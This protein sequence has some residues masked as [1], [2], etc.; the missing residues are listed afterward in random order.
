MVFLV[1]ILK[2]L[3]IPTPDNSRYTEKYGLY[4]VKKIRE[5]ELEEKQSPGSWE[6]EGLTK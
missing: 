6:K 4:I 1:M 2:N 5:N 3:V